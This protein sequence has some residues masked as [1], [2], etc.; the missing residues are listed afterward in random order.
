MF[1]TLYTTRQKTTEDEL[2]LRLDM[3]PDDSDS[4]QAKKPLLIR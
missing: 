4:A 3:K 2:W 1:D